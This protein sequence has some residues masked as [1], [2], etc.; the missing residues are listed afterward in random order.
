MNDYNEHYN[1]D[2]NNEYYD[3]EYYDNEHYHNE[4]NHN[5]QNKSNIITFTFNFI[6]ILFLLNY[7]R[8]VIMTQYKY[9]KMKKLIRGQY[10]KEDSLIRECVIC[11]EDINVNEKIIKLSCN[12]YYHK[13]CLLPWINVSK[14]CPMCRIDIP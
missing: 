3:N 12:H 7:T 5:E 4:D 14:T 8:L 1:E 6:I 9:F 13:K 2:L 10:I 11:I